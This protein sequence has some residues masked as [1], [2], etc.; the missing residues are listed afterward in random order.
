[1]ALV[2]E[3][4]RMEHFPAIPSYAKS[5]GWVPMDHL[6]LWTVCP[7]DSRNRLMMVSLAIN[8]NE[9][10]Q[11]Q[12]DA[13]RL[14]KNPEGGYSERLSMD[15]NFYYIMKE[16][17]DGNRVLLC[18]QSWFTGNNLHGWVERANPNLFEWNNRLC[19]EPNWSPAFVESH[20]KRKAN[21]YLTDQLLDSEIISS[22]TFGTS[23]GE[24]DRF[25]MYRMRPGMLRFPVLSQPHNNAIQCITF[26]DRTGNVDPMVIRETREEIGKMNF[27]F[28][29]EATTEMA[30]YFPAVKSA[31]NT[32]KVLGD[33]VRVGLVLYRGADVG[34]A[35]VEYVPL[36]DV[37]DVR[38]SSM[39][40]EAKANGRLTG[41]EQAVALSQAIETAT[42]ASKMGFK[43]S[44]SNM[45]LI[46]GNRG[47]A[48]DDNTLEGP[49]TLKRLMKNNIQMMSVQVM[50]TESGS[51][52]RFFD[53]IGDLIEA[54]IKEQYRAIEAKTEF[55]RLP[56]NE[57]Y[58]FT[59]DRKNVYFARVCFDGLGRAMTPDK[60]N[61]HIKSGIIGFAAS[62][63]TKQDVFEMA[64][65]DGG[66][67]PEPN[68]DGMKRV[69][70]ERGY[71]DYLEVK[72]FSMIKAYAKLQNND[73]SWNWHYV[74]CLLRGELEDLI[75]KLK[76]TDEAA[77][78]KSNDRSH[79][80]NAV[81]ALIKTQLP[82]KTDTE[83][84]NM[85]AGEIQ[86]TIYGFGVNILPAGMGPKYSLK[87]LANSTVVSNV[88]YFET[89]D[90]FHMR[91]EKLRLL[92]NSGYKF[93]TEVNNVLYY[94][95]PIEMLP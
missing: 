78:M 60:L 66:L 8:L 67:Y 18:K 34:Q 29:I 31:L 92:P 50:R 86:N 16:S 77:K 48:S 73:A 4:S 10:K 9:V 94:W 89:L 62:V 39:L 22:W 81:K 42:D 95:I 36:T 85:T 74:L 55:K 25:T 58:Y 26:A 2:Y 76:V 91:F 17:L 40:V 19:I 24:A 11:D 59:S 83:I 28:A 45:V 61:K 13:G 68:P 23:N 75:A 38:L 7:A 49:Q 41:H 87:D 44:Q 20:M 79:Y 1:M 71:K 14:F 90:Y 82:D 64:S 33:G 93:T 37:D 3:D 15:M 69:L 35:A 30:Q 21:F 70:G 80:I 51:R 46:I 72:A 5:R 84:E 27:I 65:D 32:C 63:S 47:N 52:A 54:N 88:A 6:L 53:Q 43:D 56:G 57:G 12:F